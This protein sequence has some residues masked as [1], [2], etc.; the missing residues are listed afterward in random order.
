[1]ARRLSFYSLHTVDVGGGGAA[2]GQFGDRRMEHTASFMAEVDWPALGIP[3]VAQ[4]DN[5][6]ALARPRF[7]N[8]FNLF[9]RTCLLFGVEVV[10][11]PP[12]ELGWMNHVESFNALWQARTIRRHRYESVEEVAASSD[13]F[14][15]YFMKRRPHPALS[16]GRHGSRFP[17]QVIEGTRQRLRFPPAG[18]T[19]EAY[20]HKDDRIRLPIARGR[21]TFLRRVHDQGWIDAGGVKVPVGKRYAGLCVTA[22]VLTYR[23]RVRVRLEGTVITEYPF[24]LPARTVRPWLN[25]A[26]DGFYDHLKAWG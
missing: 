11:A 12:N 23:Q 16:V 18:F 17:A 20:R 7:I 6:F 9:V 13:R 8:P 1:L 19:L 10:V 4:V 22:T 14:I 3:R 25:P 2:A 15:D 5:A 24:L 21:L 26:P